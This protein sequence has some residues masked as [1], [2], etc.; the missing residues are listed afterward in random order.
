MFSKYA[1]EEKNLMTTFDITFTAFI[2]LFVPMS[3]L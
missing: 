3:T 2:S 1:N